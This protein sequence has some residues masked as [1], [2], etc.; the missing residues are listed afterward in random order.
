MKTNNITLL[1]MSHPNI[2]SLSVLKSFLNVT[3]ESMPQYRPP[4]LEALILLEL[5]CRYSFFFSL[6][7]L[8]TILH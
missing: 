4:S 7:V 1:N 3:F 6:F 5:Y 8:K 2:I